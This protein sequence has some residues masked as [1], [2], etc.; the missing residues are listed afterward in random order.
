AK[1]KNN[2]KKIIAEKFGTDSFAPTNKL[3]A[4]MNIS[5]HEF[6]KCFNQTKE[7]SAYQANSFCKFLNVSINQLLDES[8]STNINWQKMNG[9]GITKD[10]IDQLIIGRK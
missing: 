8:L 3:L 6:I 9:F 1:Y 4:D 7:M 10:S 2:I 5:K